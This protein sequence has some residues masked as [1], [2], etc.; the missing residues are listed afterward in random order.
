LSFDNHR[1]QQLTKGSKVTPK[2]L[3]KEIAKR[4]VAAALKLMQDSPI[5]EVFK[6]QACH[7]VVLVPEMEDGPLQFSPYP[8]YSIRPYV[9]LEESYGARETWSAAYD[10][11]AKCKALQLWH[12]RN[13]TRTDVRPHL[14]FPGDTPYWGGVKR[15]GIVV[16]CSGVQP[17]FDQMIAGLVADMCKA[18]A[19][20]AWMN[21]DDRKN[22]QDFLT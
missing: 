8:N 21:S 16:A 14:L 2:F 11:I 3:T 17:W 1:S 13:D 12:G 5:K 15:H 6:R 18:L 22:G 4:A 9:L 7:I 19:Y 20:D 10:D